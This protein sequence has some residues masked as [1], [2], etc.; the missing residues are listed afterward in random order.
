MATCEPNIT[1]TG[2]RRRQSLGLLAGAVTIIM[3]VAAWTG[4]APVGVR[5]LVF[6]PALV[7]AL[8]LLQARRRTCV[9]RAMEGMVEQDAAR[10]ATAAPG[11][12]QASRTMAWAI[13]RDALLL[14]LLATALAAIPH[15]S[16]ARTPPT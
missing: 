9:V 8:G 3:L 2:Q 5:L 4:R 12:A 10:P 13:V 15:L 11:A 6:V 16:G 7:S 1:A 14:A